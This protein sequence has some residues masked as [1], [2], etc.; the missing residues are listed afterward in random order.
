MMLIACLLKPWITQMERLGAYPRVL[1]DDIVVYSTGH[2]H[3]DTFRM[4]F[5]C[6]H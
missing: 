5:D 2:S 6:T 3:E 4:A 1:A